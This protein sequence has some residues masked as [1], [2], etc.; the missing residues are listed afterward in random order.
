MME[1]HVVLDR[2]YVVLDRG[3]ASS[4]TTFDDANI[5]GVREVIAVLRWA[6]WHRP[7]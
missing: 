2:S 4:P 1:P 7:S 5:S 3:L 6:F